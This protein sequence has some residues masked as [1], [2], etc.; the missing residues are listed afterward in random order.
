[1]LRVCSPIETLVSSAI[2]PPTKTKPFASTARCMIGVRMLRMMLMVSSS[3]V[4][5]CGRMKA[6]DA[7]IADPDLGAAIDDQ[8]R[9]HGAGARAELEAMQRKA[10]LVIEPGVAGARAEHRQIIARLRFDAGPG[11]HDGCAAHHGEE[12]EHRALTDGKA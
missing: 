1:M 2:V 8:L 11:P 7:E 5:G 12:F 3:W 9:H 4:P 6:V 10:E